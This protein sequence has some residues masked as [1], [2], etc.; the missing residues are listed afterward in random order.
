LHTGVWFDTFRISSTVG[1]ESFTMALQ[2]K[3]IYGETIKKKGRVRDVDI[4]I[5][6]RVKEIR[7]T[8]NMS[9]TELADILDVSFQQ[10]QKYEKGLNRLSFTSILI[11]SHA[12]E[13]PLKDF[14]VRVDESVIGLSDNEQDAIS[15]Y[16]PESNV[17]QKEKKELL[18]LYCSF[19]DPKVRKHLLK[20]IKGA[21]E[22]GNKASNS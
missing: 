10:F 1:E 2:E 21:V 4:R 11:L 16:E 17:S 13:A 9:Q 6:Q 20:F 15:E 8:K 7:E 12:L 18:A 19:E 22:M 5:G 3:I 14:T